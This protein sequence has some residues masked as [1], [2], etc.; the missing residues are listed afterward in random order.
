M[1]DRPDLR[2]DREPQT[3]QE[4]EKW[5]EDRDPAVPLTPREWL[6]V[7]KFTAKR[8]RECLM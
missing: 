5:L 4:M 2:H 7:Q 6:I 8:P 1:N 3:R